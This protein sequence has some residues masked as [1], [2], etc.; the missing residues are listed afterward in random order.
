MKPF[1]REK[2]GAIYGEWQVIKFHRIDG[3]SDARWWCKC[4]KCGKVYSVRGF[5]FEKRNYQK[6]QTVRSKGAVP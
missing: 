6:M 2:E 4:K 3:H 5:L 1:I